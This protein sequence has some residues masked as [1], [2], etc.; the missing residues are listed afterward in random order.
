[1]T[2][3]IIKPFEGDYP[4]TQEFGAKYKY[5]GKTITHY[6]VDFAC[7]K[8]TP[9]LACDDG[10]VCLVKRSFNPF[11][12]GKEVRIQHIQLMS[13]YAHLSKIIVKPFQE[14]E[15]GQI[16]GYS[17]R[18]GFVLGRT[19]YHLHFGIKRKDEWIDPKPLYLSPFKKNGAQNAPVSAEK[20][21]R[22][23]KGRLKSYYVYQVQSGDSL[24]KIAKSIYGDGNKWRII[25]EFNIK[26]I[27]KPNKVYPGQKLIIPGI[28]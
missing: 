8:G 26:C 20:V 17:G 10:H 19:G 7:P 22:P 5:K 6:G 27:R 2:T 14:V 28:E 23:D 3:E 21:S 24:F 11:N 13:Q 12:Y 25:Y 4:I 9:I 18:T 1:M 15:R 16:I